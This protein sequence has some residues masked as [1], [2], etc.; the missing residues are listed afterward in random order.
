MTHLKLYKRSGVNAFENK[1]RDVQVKSIL[2]EQNEGL[3]L[4]TADIDLSLNPIFIF[5]KSTPLEKKHPVPASG[6]RVLF[7]SIFK[8]LNVYLEKIR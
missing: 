3:V 8:F 7:Q 4:I 1:M 6:N 2:F 5:E